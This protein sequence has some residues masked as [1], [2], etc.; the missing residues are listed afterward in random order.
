[1]KVDKELRDIVVKYW[2]DIV[3]MAEKY[4]IDPWKLV[5]L[6]DDNVESVN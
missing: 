4:N 2:T 3:D 1:M 5:R 6:E